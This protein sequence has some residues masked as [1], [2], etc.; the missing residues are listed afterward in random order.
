M[1][2]NGLVVNG[3]QLTINL[4]YVGGPGAV[5]VKDSEGAIATLYVTASPLLS[6]LSVSPT[7]ITLP[8]SLQ[9]VFPIRLMRGKPFDTYPPYLVFTSHPGLLWPSVSGNTVTVTSATRPCVSE[10]T[11]VIITVIDAS[12]ASASTTATIQDN[13]ACP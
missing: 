6:R 10:N 5:T 11:D 2:G 7:E 3:D 4:Q 1:I 9:T 12:G 8:E 13:G